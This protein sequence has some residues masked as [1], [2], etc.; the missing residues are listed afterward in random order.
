[1]SSFF[2]L[3][4]TVCALTGE[5]SDIMLGVYKTDMAVMQLPK[6]STLKESVT[7]TNRLTTNSQLS[8]FN[9]VVTNGCYQP[10]KA[11]N[12]RKAG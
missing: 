8:N 2:A 12:P 10:L 11:Q 4:V 7:R 5:C 9:R 6:S 3:I 1:M